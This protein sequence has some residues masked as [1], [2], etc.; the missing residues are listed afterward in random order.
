MSATEFKGRSGDRRSLAASFLLGLCLCLLAGTAAAVPIAGARTLYVAN[1]SSN[2]VS[3]VDT[4]SN[5]VI[6][7]SL[8]VG[9]EP[10]EI[11]ISPDGNRAYVTNRVSEDIFAIDTR[12]NQVVGPPIQVG[13]DPA[14]LAITPDGRRAFVAH[15]DQGT[16]SVV[17]LVAN[18]V[19]GSPIT[20][21]GL[22]RGIAITPD[23]SRAYV[24]CKGS[25]SVFVIDTATNQVVGPQ[26]EVG[27][28]PR[29]I[30]I[31]PDGLRAYVTNSAFD[32]DV[33]VIDLLTNRTVGAP[34]EVGD[35]PSGI[36]ITPDGSRAYVASESTGSISVVALAANQVTG[37]P[38][39]VGVD[40][41]SIAITPDGSRA[42]VTNEASG[43]VS[44]IDTVANQVI[45]GPIKVGGTP[46][47]IA[48][49]PAQAPLASFKALRARPG[50]PV[51]FDAAGSTDPDGTISLYTWDFGDRGV[52]AQAVPRTSHTYLRPGRY[53]ASLR[54]TDNEGCSTSLIFTGQTAFCNGQASAQTSQA[55]RVDFPGVRIG[56]PGRAGPKG[57]HFRLRVIAKRPKSGQRFKAESAV[58]KATVKR[59]HSAIVFLR[60]KKPFRAKLA[61]AKS[62]LVMVADT[63]RHSRPPSFRRMKIVR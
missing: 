44:V 46:F 17:D 35:N 37:E 63:S 57:C 39:K 34:I 14:A 24:V 9:G 41:R 3:V 60:P 1:Q 27:E 47:G 50:V 49:P 59:R 10:R 42:Y 61:R 18:Q 62:V 36:A 6:G 21:G 4:G 15:L 55:I 8:A 22:P 2:S 32:D 19:V 13:N 56:C 33:S 51:R 58:A 29:S 25:D 45:G 12:T 20:V 5:Q 7:G 43:D 23:G 26:I 53:I 52:A 31:T 38:I 16:V 54:L 40:P 30:A 11:A 28:S 48:T